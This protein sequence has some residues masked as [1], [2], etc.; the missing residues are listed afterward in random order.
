RILAGGG[1]GAG[2][3]SSLGHLS[4]AGSACRGAVAAGVLEPR[5]SAP[6]SGTE[7]AGPPRSSAPRRRALGG[8]RPHRPARTRPPWPSTK[9]TALLAP[10]IAAG[11]LRS[12]ARSS[13]HRLLH[14]RAD[15]CL[16]GGGQLR[17]SEGGR[18][19]GAVVEVRLV[20]EGERRVPG[21]ELLRALEEADDLAV[22]GISGH[23]VPGSRRQCWRAGFDDGMEPLAQQ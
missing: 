7:L 6:G 14:E 9:T 21:L 4:P 1:G 20:A 2:G 22:L 13:A 11:S 8:W 18:P 12:V 23:P 10:V 5:P 15:P 17:H 3:A 16:V 19:H